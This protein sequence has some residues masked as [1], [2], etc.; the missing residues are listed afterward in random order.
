MEI[1][2]THERINEKTPSGGDYSEIYFFDDTGN[3]V[4]SKNA[5]KCVIRECKNDGSLIN[6][7][8]GIC[9]EK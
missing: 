9:N 1:G 2:M 5:K 8:W 3:S 6:E 7:T 4:D